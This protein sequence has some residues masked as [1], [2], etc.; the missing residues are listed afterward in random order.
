LGHNMEDIC[1]ILS[2]STENCGRSSRL[3][4]CKS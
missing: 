3:N 1:H 4:F 2:K